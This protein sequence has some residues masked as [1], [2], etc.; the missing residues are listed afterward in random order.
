MT[1]RDVPEPELSGLDAAGWLR[2]VLRGVPLALLIFGGFVLLLLLRLIERPLFGPQRPMTPFITGFVCRTALRILG[3]RYTVH[4]K[5]MDHPGGVVSNHASWLDILSLNASQRVYFVSKA[6]V[7]AWPGIGML[8]RGVGT[9]FIRRDPRDAGAQKTT[10]EARL[11]AGH[12][13]LFFPEGTSSD[14]LRVL[15][16]KSTLFAAFFSDALRQFS[17]IQP[18]SVSYIAPDAKNPHFYGWWGDME[19][20]PHMLQVLAA[21]MQGRIEV[22]YHAPLKVADFADR[23]QLAAACEAAVRSGLSVSER[24]EP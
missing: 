4:G 9:V 17:Y 5:P 21:P 7:A 24:S 12:K 22:T 14:G 3:I 15:P 1:W 19:F 13:L 11:H 18:A 2:A 8:A 10:F 20:A 23:K 6:D 16:F